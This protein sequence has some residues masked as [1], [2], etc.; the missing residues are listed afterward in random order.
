MAR[1]YD[2]LVRDRI[3]EIIEKNGEEPI[4]H[5]IERDEY[6]TRLLEKLDEE[7]DEYREGCDIEELADIL[8]VVHAIR[9]ERGVT[10]EELQEIREQKAEQRGRF[11]DRIILDS[12][13]E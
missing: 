11:E 10:V 5:T 13:E 1:Q 9:K 2:K 3:P 6:A 7:V 4:T 8:E 12:V